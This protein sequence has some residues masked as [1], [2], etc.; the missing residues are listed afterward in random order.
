MESQLELNNE[1]MKLFDKH[2]QALPALKVAEDSVR[3]EVYKDGALNIK[4]KRLMS[5]GIALRTGCTNC[6]LS[7]TMHALKAGATRDEILETTSV[8]VS[9][10]G[11]L[12]V[13]E[14]LRVVKL[15]DELGKL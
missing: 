12:A 4:V 10:G 5:L 7:Q 1:R 3:A 15:L 14:S 9:M 6:I 8:A 11:T 13:A 2:G